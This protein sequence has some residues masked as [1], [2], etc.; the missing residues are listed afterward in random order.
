MEYILEEKG[1]SR[2][3]FA[4]KMGID[5]EKKV[6]ALFAGSLP[7]NDKMA[8]K[9]AEHLGSTK[10]FWLRSEEI[11]HQHLRFIEEA[12]SKKSLAWLETLPKA[13]RWKYRKHWV[14]D[15]R[16]AK[17][18]QVISWLRFFGV[19][20][21]EDFEKDERL[22]AYR[23]SPAFQHDE[24]SVA[25]WF[26]AC[27]ILFE[28]DESVQ[29]ASYNKAAFELQLQEIRGSLLCETDP[30]KFLP[31]LKEMLAESGVGIVFYPTPRG[32]PLFGATEWIDGNRFLILQSVRYLSHDKSLVYLLP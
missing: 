17:Y 23:A 6:K 3:L 7:I 31:K 29:V 11:Y 18:R 32:C 30:R 24:G 14:A 28:E 8:G 27:E 26:R 5:T 19:D 12:K 4:Q 15:G 20:S 25:A 22:A 9:L 16:S 21:I 13:D 10:E 2:G 1:W